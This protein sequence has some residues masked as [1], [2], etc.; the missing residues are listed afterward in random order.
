M[1]ELRKFVRGIHVFEA[2]F[3]R[4][5]SRGR[6]WQHLAC[7]SSVQL[8]RGFVIVYGFRGFLLLPE[9]L[10]GEDFRFPLAR[11]I[12]FRLPTPALAAG[13]GAIISGFFH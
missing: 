6:G 1:Q 2:D 11:G 9:E 10:E 3:C 7:S 13:E 5:A 4:C 8:S 12:I